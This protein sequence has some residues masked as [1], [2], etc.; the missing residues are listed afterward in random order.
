MIEDQL[1]IVLTK[2]YLECIGGWRK[3]KRGEG[4]FERKGV[5]MIRKGEKKG[6][7][8]LREGSKGRGEKREGENGGDG[9]VIRGKKSIKFVRCLLF[10]PRLHASTVLFLVDYSDSQVHTSFYILYKKEYIS[11]DASAR[12]G[13]KGDVSNL[14]KP[15]RRQPSEGQEAALRPNHGCCHGRL[16]I[17][18]YQRLEKEGGVGGRVCTAADNTR[19]ECLVVVVV[20]AFSGGGV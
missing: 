8:V 10:L 1:L 2:E 18:V 13:E 7:K 19:C 4:E 20:V 15:P 17:V 16:T 3:E 14:H 12:R 5:E 9:G 11:E 6:A